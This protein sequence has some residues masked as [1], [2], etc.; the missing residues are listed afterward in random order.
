VPPFCPYR[1]GPP[2]SFDDHPVAWAGSALRFAHCFQEQ[3]TEQPRIILADSGLEVVLRHRPET[4]A[5]DLLRTTGVC[6]DKESSLF[7]P[8][9][10]DVAMNPLTCRGFT[11][12]TRVVRS[13]S[14]RSAS[15]AIVIHSLVERKSKIAWSFAVMAAGESLSW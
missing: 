14:M 10:F 13:I 15:S 12:R 4:L 6:Q 1:A 11:V 9:T 7:E 3:R 5:F 2:F 8:G